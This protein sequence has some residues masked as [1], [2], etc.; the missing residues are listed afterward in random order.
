MVKNPNIE[1]TSE[2]DKTLMNIISVQTLYP[3]S[4]GDFNHA[5]LSS[6]L[7]TFTQY[8]KPLQVR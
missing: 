5:S 3:N 2:I 6:T 1:I 8:V 4:Y 7:P